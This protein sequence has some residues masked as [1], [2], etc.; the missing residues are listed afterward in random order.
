MS[1]INLCKL[2]P[3]STKRVSLGTI[4][5]EDLDFLAANLEEEFEEDVEYFIDMDTIDYLREQGASDRLL[6]M[7]QKALASAEEGVEIAYQVL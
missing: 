7:L 6:A 3:D 1:T 5:D 2:D 4:S